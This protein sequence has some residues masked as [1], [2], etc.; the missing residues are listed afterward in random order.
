MPTTIKL[1]A[2]VDSN[3]SVAVGSATAHGTYAND[4]MPMGTLSFASGGQPFGLVE[5]ILPF[6]QNGATAFLVD[7]VVATLA[8]SANTLASVSAASYVMGTPVA[9][10]PSPAGLGKRFASRRNPQRRCRFRLLWPT[11]Q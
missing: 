6:Q 9:S 5:L 7:S 8:A 10:G 4:T 1:T 11:R 2:Y 3:K